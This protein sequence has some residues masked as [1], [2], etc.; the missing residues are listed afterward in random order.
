MLS[1]MVCAVPTGHAAPHRRIERLSAAVAA[2]AE[3]REVRPVA[4][5][6]RLF[7]RVD[8][9]H[10]DDQG[11]GVERM[12]DL[13]LVRVGD[14]HAGHRLGVR[15]GRPH[16]ADA[17]PRAHVVLHLGPDEVV[18][19]VGHRAVGGRIGGAE[20]R[21]AGHLAPLLHLQLHG[22]PDLRPGR[23]IECRTVLPSRRVERPRVHGPVR[24]ARG[25]AAVGAGGCGE[26]EVGGAGVRVVQ[27]RVGALWL[28]SPLRA[29]C[30]GRGALGCAG[31]LCGACAATMATPPARAGIAARDMRCFT[32]PSTG[33]GGPWGT[34]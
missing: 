30:V 14:A 34:L 8:R 3:R 2:A 33:H 20:D 13:A 15:A 26:R 27:V 6:D 10:D 17:F 25:R 29:P 7:D 21:A 5:L 31:G 19:G 4:R 18:A 32:G 11:T 24:R 16:A 23:R 9:R 28:L 22:V 12:L 1:L